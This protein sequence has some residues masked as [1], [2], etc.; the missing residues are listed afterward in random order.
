MM[1]KRKF[2]LFFFVLGI[3]FNSLKLQAQSLPSGTAGIVYI[4]DGAGDRI[5]RH[6]VINSTSGTA[7]IVD[8]QKVTKQNQ[9]ANVLKVDVLYPNPTSGYFTVRMVKQLKDAMVMITDVSGRLILRRKESG[10]VLNYNLSK[11]PS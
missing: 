7:S 2:L 3:L 11:E 5:D 9:S 6:Y 10:F 1:K 4:Y 8:N